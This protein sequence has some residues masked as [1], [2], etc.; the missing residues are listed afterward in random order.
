MTS[1]LQM[2]SP[3]PTSSASSRKP[4][5]NLRGTT[6]DKTKA[7]IA[8]N[9][10]ITKKPSLPIRSQN[11]KSTNIP[12]NTIPVP[13]AATSISR[14]TSLLP[15][16]ST[17]LKKK[18]EGKKIDSVTS[19]ASF[20]PESSIKSLTSSTRLQEPKKVV[21]EKK[22]KSTSNQ[23]SNLKDLETENEDLKLKLIQINNESE[24]SKKKL[25]VKYLKDLKEKEEIWK[26]EIDEVTSTN[27]ELKQELEE[28]KSKLDKQVEEKLLI[29][30]EP[31]QKSYDDLKS[32]QSMIE[33]KNDQ[34]HK[35]QKQNE[36][37][38]VEVIKLQHAM[39]Q[40]KVKEHENEEQKLV[41][42]NKSSEI[43]RLELELL[44]AQSTCS[45]QEKENLKLKQD[46]EE[47]NFKN[48]SFSTHDD[49]NPFNPV[50]ETSIT[51]V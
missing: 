28:L 20:K 34:I 8:R 7:S 21:L 31:Y 2:A 41:L 18:A 15:P 49:K 24:S 27:E 50:F 30:I 16:P 35:L 43:T 37:Y 33:L 48:S 44:A 23:F 47:L 1:L 3:V 29:L 51:E 19:S 13:S 10:P 12:K 6:T 39:N 5:Y 4:A 22:K 40:L 42:K 26:K 46:I 38:K 9:G 17:G 45:E 14:R 32:T 36:L 25:K 11:K